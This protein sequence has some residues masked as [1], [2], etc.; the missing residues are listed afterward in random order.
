MSEWGGRNDSGR[1]GEWP[2]GL[3]LQG[4]QTI[5]VKGSHGKQ[6]LGPTPSPSTHLRILSSR[7]LDLKV[8]GGRRR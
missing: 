4:C 7:N 6:R 1:V 2:S 8:C 3:W 5:G